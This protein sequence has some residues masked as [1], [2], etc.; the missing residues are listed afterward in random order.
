MNDS[1]LT[2]LKKRKAKLVIG[3]IEYLNAGEEDFNPGYTE[4]D[5]E[6][7]EV[8]LDSFLAS[9][10]KLEQDP[11]ESEIM[12]CVKYVV[13][14]LNKI[15]DRTGGS[16]IETDQRE[17]LWAYIDYAARGSGLKKPG[18]ITEEWRRW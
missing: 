16:L 18:D 12:E 11:A 2:E 3:M 5:I 13:T 9:L 7:C 8:V 14:K 15:N 4:A 10:E 1:D 17:Q 6:K